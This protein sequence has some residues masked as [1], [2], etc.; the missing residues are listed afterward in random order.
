MNGSTETSD[1]NNSD[2]PKSSS[3][4]AAADDKVTPDEV[5]QAA[6]PIDTTQPTR[7][8]AEIPL[9]LFIF[10]FLMLCLMTI[11]M[12]LSLGIVSNIHRDEVERWCLVLQTVAFVTQ[13]IVIFA[14]GFEELYWRARK[15]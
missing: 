15:P 1:P 13:S 7:S 11:A 10:S 4:A 6:K 2:L 9:K 3:V 12:F 8:K 14:A 5:S